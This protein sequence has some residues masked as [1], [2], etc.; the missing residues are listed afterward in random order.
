ME[1][2]ITYD[3]HGGFYDHVQTPVGVPISDDIVRPE[4]LNFKFDRLGVRP[5][6]SLFPRGLKQELLFI[7][8]SGH[9]HHQSSSI[10]LFLQL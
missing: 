10:L 3:E 4:L 9:I 8:L 2:I 6:S 7:D 1:L 5:R